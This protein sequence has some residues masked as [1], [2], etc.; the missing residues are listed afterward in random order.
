MLRE[1]IPSPYTAQRNKK[2]MISDTDHRL[3]LLPLHIE[4]NITGVDGSRT[5]ETPSCIKTTRFSTSLPAAILNRS[6]R[7]DL[8]RTIDVISFY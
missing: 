3:S 4:K 5:L 8:C 7:C 1:G 6:G 2:P